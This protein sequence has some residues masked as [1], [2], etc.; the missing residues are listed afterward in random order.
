[1]SK[2]AKAPCSDWCDF[3]P[4]RKRLGYIKLQAT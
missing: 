3:K 4:S 2:D 1:M